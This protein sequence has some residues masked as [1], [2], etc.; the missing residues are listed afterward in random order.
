M[1]T[2]AEKALQIHRQSYEYVHWDHR[3]D[4]RVACAVISIPWAKGI[5]IDTAFD[6]ARRT[7][8]QVHDEILVEAGVITR[9][10][11]RAGGIEG[12]VTNGQPLVVRAAMKPI[13][14]TLTPLRSVDL[15]TRRPTLT[16]YQRSDICA[17]PAAAIVG[18]AMLA[19][20]LAD[21][22]LEKLGGDSLAEMKAHWEGWRSSCTTMVT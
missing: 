17:V 4:A 14:T 1:R 15:A 9:R 11:N 3:L 2:A 13:P 20:V 5:E 18:E 7:G 12:G 8:T 21:A 16:Q 19:W 10:T 22:L 6:N